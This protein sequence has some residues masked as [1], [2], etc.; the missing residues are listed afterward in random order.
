MGWCTPSVSHYVIDAPPRALRWA[1]VIDGH[2][3]AADLAAAPLRTE[4]YNVEVAT[5]GEGGIEAALAR[6]HDVVVL[7]TTLPGMT[8]TAV[9]RH[10]RAFGLS[11]AIVFYA[12][13][14][15]LAAR[16]A[17]LDAGADDYIGKSTTT[18]ELVARVRAVVRRAHQEVPDQLRF[19][20][21]VLDGSRYEVRRAGIRIDLTPTQ[22][23]LL[24]YLMARPDRV[25]SKDVLLQ[26]VWGR[27]WNEDDNLIETCMG[28]LRVKLGRHGP[29]LIR[30][31]R[32]RGYL[33]Q[34]PARPAGPASPR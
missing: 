33:L 11:T 29:P 15:T 18:A 14:V 5:T 12:S 30:T 23:R 32:H 25:V 28:R 21:L 6:Q 17:A 3:A 34:T 20:D 22:Y 19:G 4:G 26:D 9:A 27:A 2:L 13:D 10:L 1:L 24:R 7:E 31:V 16:L 8:G